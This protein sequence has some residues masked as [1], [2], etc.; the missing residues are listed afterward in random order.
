MTNPS[1]L[2]RRPHRT[3]RHRGLVAV[4]GVGV[5]AIPAAAGQDAPG[6]PEPAPLKRSIEDRLTISGV[7]AGTYQFQAASGENLD[8]GIVTVRPTIEFELSD[9]DLLHLTFGLAGG[10]AIN[11]VT[12]FALNPLAKDA[13]QDLKDINGS[14]RDYIQTAWYQHTTDFAGGS[15]AI[16]GGIIDST[17][18]LDQNSFANDEYNQFLNEAFVNAPVGFFQSYSPGVALAWTGD[19]WSVNASLMRVAE[20]DDGEDFLHAGIQFGYRTENA[21][22]EGNYRVTMSWADSKFLDATG[23]TEEGRLAIVGSVDQMVSE[24]VG[25]WGRLGMQDDA[26]AITHEWMLTGGVDVRGDGW[27]RPQDNAGLGLGWLDGGNAGVESTFVAEAYVR[28][29]LTEDIAFSLD[30]QYM[31]DSVAMGDGLDGAIFGARLTYE[32]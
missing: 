25:V 26:A 22:G 11:D 16:V 13:E 18:Y 29:A 24:T 4:V 3:A 5:A 2:H 23:T 21:L 1:S 32:F 20:N 19:A 14:G 28:F 9:R 8:G 10:N 6:I 30:A 12:S 15:L 31:D 17:E 27:G 7:M